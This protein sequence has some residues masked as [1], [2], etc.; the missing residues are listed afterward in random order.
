[1]R[2]Q[3]VA[4]LPDLAH[5][6]QYGGRHGPEPWSPSRPSLTGEPSKPRAVRTTYAYEESLDVC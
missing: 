5:L 2:A 3:G 4:H 6:A 1:M